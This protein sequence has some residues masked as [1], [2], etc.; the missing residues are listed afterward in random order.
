MGIAE[1]ELRPVWIDLCGDERHLLILGDAGS[2]KTTALRS[3]LTGMVA[4]YPA[5]DVRAILLDYRHG[6]MDVV[7]P[8]HLGAYAG[9]ADTAAAYVQQVVERLSQRVPPPDITVSRLHAR[10]WWTGPELYV[11]VDDYDMV[12]TGPQGVLSPLVRFLPQAREVGLHLV[13]AR[14][15]SGMSRSGLSDPVLNR[16]RDLGCTGLVMSG[17]FREGVV[18]GGERAAI[19]PP[20]RGVLLRRSHPIELIQVAAPDANQP[21][22][23]PVP[24]GA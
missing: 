13:L 9:D 16:I 20:G 22:R 5:T 3:W 6:L 15:V 19:R 18:F 24:V 8:E 2:G 1:R 21:D 7:P 12:A 10:D 14:R 4:T 23:P 11:V 17:D